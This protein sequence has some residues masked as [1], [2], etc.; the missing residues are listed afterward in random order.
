MSVKNGINGWAG[1]VLRVNLSTGTITVLVDG[2]PVEVTAAL[3]QGNYYVSL[4]TVNSLLGIQATQAD[5]VISLTADKADA[6][7]GNAG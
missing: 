5:G 2:K 6:G 3:Y 4:D 7:N 1:T